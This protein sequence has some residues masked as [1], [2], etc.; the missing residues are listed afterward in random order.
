MTSAEK[1]IYRNSSK[2]KALRLLILQRDSDTCQV[3]GLVRRRALQIHH[4]DENKYNE[5]DEYDYLVTLCSVCHKYFERK[6]AVLNNPKNSTG[7]W[8]SELRRLARQIC[9]SVK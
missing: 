9:R 2:W 7:R 6:V 4:L 8:T 3:C 1:K 5:M